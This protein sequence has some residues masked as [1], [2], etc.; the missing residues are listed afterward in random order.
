M[1]FSSVPLEQKLKAQGRSLLDYL[2]EEAFDYLWLTG[3]SRNFF[4]EYA[5]QHSYQKVFS[6]HFKEGPKDFAY[7]VLK[8]PS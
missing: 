2:N 5:N 1:V 8:K 3:D 7:V 6:Y 4:W